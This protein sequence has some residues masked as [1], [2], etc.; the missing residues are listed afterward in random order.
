[1]KV[2]DILDTFKKSVAKLQAIIDITN[3]LA[4]HKFTYTEALEV[5]DM[6]LD[7]ISY[8]KDCDEFETVDDYFA[9]KPC[10]DITK[11]VITP[12]NKVN[13]EKELLKSVKKLRKELDL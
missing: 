12:L 6:L 11:K 13:M 9:H 2:G 3:Y 7:Q 1:M 8:S 4:D 10:C 5:A